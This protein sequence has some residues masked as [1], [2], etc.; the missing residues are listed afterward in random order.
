MPD[1]RN[2]II[3]RLRG[4]LQQLADDFGTDASGITEQDVIPDTGI[5]DSAGVIEFVMLIDNA[6][7]LAL[8]A[9]DMTIDNLGTLSAIAAFIVSRQAVQ[10]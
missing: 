3:T 2:A 6:Y 7:D 9:E 1:D 10:P 4:L 8:E 5:L